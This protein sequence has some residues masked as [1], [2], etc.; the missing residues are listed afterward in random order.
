MICAACCDGVNE[1]PNLVVRVVGARTLRHMHPFAPA[2]DF[3]EAIRAVRPTA[4]WRRVYPWSLHPFEFRRV[5]LHRQR[6][7][8]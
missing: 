5:L 8:N 6:S 2:S 4:F 3:A 7:L 1:S